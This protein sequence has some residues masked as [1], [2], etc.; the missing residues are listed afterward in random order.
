M[1]ITKDNLDIPFSTLIEDATNP[2]TPR[3]FIRCSEAEFGLNKA[4][5]ESM[6]EDELSSYIEHLD[7][8]WDK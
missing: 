2:E 4:D 5:L 8:L 6:S 7:Y 1:Q 3:E